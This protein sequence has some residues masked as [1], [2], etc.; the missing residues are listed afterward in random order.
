[1]EVSLSIFELIHIDIKVHLIEKKLTIFK[2]ED[3]FE[4]FQAH[5]PWHVGA[6]S[7]PTRP[8]LTM[9]DQVWGAKLLLQPFVWVAT[10]SVL[11]AGI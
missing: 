8:P 9:K 2:G 4:Y 10:A 6:F 3:E 7:S 5:P 11:G 1:M